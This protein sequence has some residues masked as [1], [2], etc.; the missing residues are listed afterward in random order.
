MNI[1]GFP[2]NIAFY[3]HGLHLWKHNSIDYIFA[4]NHAYI[5]GGERVEIFRIIDD[6]HLEYQ[7]SIIMGQ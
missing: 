4:V 5:Y 7:H 2:S 3:P 1:N 6:L